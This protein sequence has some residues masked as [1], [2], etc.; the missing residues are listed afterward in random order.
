MGQWFATLNRADSSPPLN[1]HPGKSIV[2]FTRVGGFPDVTRFLGH[3]KRAL[4][5]EGV[6]VEFKEVSLD[7]LARPTFDTTQS[8]AVISFQLG[9]P[10]RM[11]WDGEVYENL[12]RTFRAGQCIIC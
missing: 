1:Q 12:Q 6:D 11:E 4:H 10:E 7:P 9:D 2:A 3:V 5:R 8:K